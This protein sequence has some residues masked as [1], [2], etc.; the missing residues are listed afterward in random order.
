M[1]SSLG[2]LETDLIQHKRLGPEIPAGIL[3]RY[4]RDLN[5]IQKIADSSAA[6]LILWFV[7]LSHEKPI[8][9]LEKA[10]A[11]FAVLFVL[12]LSS[13]IGLYISFRRD[14][15]WSLLRRILLLWLGLIG[16]TSIGLIIF[17]VADKISHEQLTHWFTAYGIYLVISHVCSRQLLRKL[18]VR[19]RN[20]RC[21]GYIG[22]NEGLR[23][24]EQQLRD[25]SWLGHH[26][27]AKLC[28]EKGMKLQSADIQKLREGFSQHLPDQWLVEEPS[29]AKILDEVL[30]CLQDQPSPVL[31]LPRWLNGSHYKPRYCQL[32][33]I[34]AIEISGCSENATPLQLSM[35]HISDRISASI[36]LALIS[37][38]MLIIALAIKL[39]SPGSILFKQRRYGLNGQSF[40]CLKFR[41]MVAEENGDIVIQATR[42][43]KRI[44]R[45]G[46][47]LRV[48]NL[49]ELPQLVNICCGEMSMVGPRPH[50]AAHNEYYRHKVVAYM[51]RH[52]LKPGLTGWAQVQGL[53]GETDTIE[54]MKARVNADIEYIQNWN[55]MLDLKILM[56]TFLR[57]RNE[58]A[59]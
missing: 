20:T 51:Q 12:A 34:G 25:A 30:R 10:V 17:K 1:A 18:R 41:T 24:I 58:N 49:D 35:K 6:G 56:L 42:G 33:T 11:L 5:R 4:S 32:G 29:D 39:E 8:G 38:L 44:T 13:R 54:K 14:S 23:R 59:Y 48:W 22:S 50:A 28:W 40:N 52:S 53:R 19:G 27:E 2:A 16:A 36:I 7:G 3:R 46:A 45:V 47:L 31:L 43:D 21:D 26:V 15:H 9:E 55:L 57:W 37:P